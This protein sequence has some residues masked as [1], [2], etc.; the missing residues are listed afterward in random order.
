M[1]DVI[2]IILG[3]DKDT[4][5]SKLPQSVA[6]PTAPPLN[7]GSLSPTKTPS[8]QRMEEDDTGKCG[9]DW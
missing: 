2:I 8:P 4:V 6:P 1:W 5:M 9:G 3:Q 7:K